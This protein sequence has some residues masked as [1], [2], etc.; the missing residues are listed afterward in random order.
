M[1]N[2]GNIPDTPGW[3]VCHGMQGQGSFACWEEAVKAGDGLAES[4]RDAAGV[5]TAVVL[6]MKSR[7]SAVVSLYEGKAAGTGRF[8]PRRCALSLVA[9]SAV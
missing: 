1:W 2:R 7:D 5:T 8:L 6:E 9:A 3:D 4:R